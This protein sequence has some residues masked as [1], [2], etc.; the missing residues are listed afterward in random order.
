MNRTHV[1][2]TG[3]GNG[4]GAGIARAF[5]SS[6]C[7]VS[8]VDIR[9]D[10][11]DKQFAETAGVH[12]FIADLALEADSIIDRIWAHSGP[13]DVLV[14]AAGIYPAVQVLDIDTAAWDRVLNVNTRA[15]MLTTIAFAQ[16]AIKAGRR[17]SVINITSGA[18]VRSR[19]GG[20]L[21]ATSKAALD[22]ATRA[23]ALELGPHGIRVNAVSP[24][25]V[26]VDSD[27][28]PVTSEYAA[29]LSKNPLGRPGTPQD[30][31]EAVTWLAS[32]AADWITGAT[33]RVDGGS[34]T[35]ATH[36][37]I[38]WPAITPTQAG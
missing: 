28:N 26:T 24:G 4:I 3:A 7:L 2:V 32:D 12:R 37:P 22:M 25:F 6:G 30:I 16:H 34:G 20:A 29:A 10:L 23:A 17:G 33:L 1:V 5:L 15:P 38:H 21:Y 19:P 14:N 36:L 18:A 8:A 9:E 35:G 13:V 11:L 31:A 27:V